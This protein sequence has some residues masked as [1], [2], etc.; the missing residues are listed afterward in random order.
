MDYLQSGISLG[1]SQVNKVREHI[2][3]KTE[4]TFRK[5]GEIRP[6]EFQK[7]GDHLTHQFRKWEWCDADAEN[8]RSPA[9]KTWSEKNPV[10]LTKQYLVQRGV[11]CL[12]RM[13]DHNKRAKGGEEDVVIKDGLAGGKGKGSAGDGGDDDDGWLRTG[14]SSGQ[15]G[16]SQRKEGDVQDVRT[17][18]EKG[19]V[20]DAKVVE[21]DYV[22]DMDDDEDDDEAIVKDNEGTSGSDPYVPLSP[23]LKF[24]VS[25][26]NPSSS[27]RK[28]NVYIAYSNYY[29][30]PRLYLSGYDH[31]GN[32]LS[33]AEMLEDLVEEYAD[34]TVTFEDF[35]HFKSTV[36]MASIHPCQHANVMKIFLDNA[37]RSLRRRMDKQAA[38]AANKDLVEG[39]KGL[40]VSGSKTTGQEVSGG[41]E[42]EILDEAAEPEGFHRED[43]F[44]DPDSALQV[45]QY[46]VVFLKFAGSMVPT[47]DYDQTMAVG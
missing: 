19:D 15:A 21:D 36:K 10:D 42:W 24:A 20:E 16:N 26:L 14:G 25:S 47:I 33:W 3:I 23:T 43:P 29:K 13:A 27:I 40:S 6:A 5:N 44:Y 22:P 4:S 17:V 1:R 11:P 38:A 28:Y 46:L 45:H 37:D 39:V 12:H 8:L 30:T 35:P 2:P 32:P 41:D 34:K 7:A 9:M 31:A 18:D